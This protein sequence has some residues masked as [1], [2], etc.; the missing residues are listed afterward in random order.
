[1]EYRTAIWNTCMEGGRTRDGSYLYSVIEREDE[2]LILRYRMSAQFGNAAL[3]SISPAADWL[4]V[5]TIRLEILLSL[6]AISFILVIYLGKML[7][8]L[9]T[10]VYI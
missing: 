4:L 8:K 9:L 1:M 3:R 7:Y 5:V 2:I 10:V 6:I